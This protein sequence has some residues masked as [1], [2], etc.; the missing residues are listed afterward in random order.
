MN[1]LAPAIGF[2]VCWLS[3][4]W[5]L[6][7]D[8]LP[9]DHP[10]A[11][12]LH[13]TPTPR[14]GGLGIMLG[15]GVAGLW[16]ADGPLLVLTLAIAGNALKAFPGVGTISGGVVHAVAY[17]MIFDSLGRAA[18][19]T[20]ASRGELRAYPAARAFEDLMNEHLES[21]AGRFAKIAITGRNRE[22]GA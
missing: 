14:I 13:E 19:Q 21:G 7:H 17:G 8:F 9:M 18:A 1:W 22:D 5:L 10:N 2:V 12:S 4:T 6:R 16:L 15:L 3:L 20:M 11:R